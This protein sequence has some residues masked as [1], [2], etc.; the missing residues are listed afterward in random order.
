MHVI[1]IRERRSI[2]DFLG[3]LSRSG[4]I[5]GTR[6]EGFGL[7]NVLSGGR[8]RN[9]HAVGTAGTG[10]GIER[11]FKFIEVV[12]FIF[13]VLLA[14]VVTKLYL[15]NVIHKLRFDIRTDHGFSFVKTNLN[16]KN[17]QTRYDECL[18]KMYKAT[19]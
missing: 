3:G 1:M 11:K 2:S 18:Y 5:G 12:R 6:V 8:C 17:L 9:C 16:L 13:V 14:S 15:A 7:E 19:M 4:M 10:T